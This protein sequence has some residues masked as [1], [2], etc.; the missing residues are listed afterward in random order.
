MLETLLILLLGLSALLDTSA[1]NE[2]LDPDAERCQ[3][4]ADGLLSLSSCGITD[5]DFDDI[6]SCLDAA[7]PE[8]I[9]TL[10]LSYNQ[11]STLPE[12]IFG[13]LTALETLHLAS[14]ELTTL[15]QGIFGGLPALEYLR[16][17]MP[18]ARGRCEGR[19]Q[20]TRSSPNSLVIRSHAYQPPPCSY[21][22]PRTPN[23]CFWK[24]ADPGE[25]ALGVFQGLPTLTILYLEGN[26]LECLP[27]T[28]LV[29]V[30]DDASTS[31]NG[32]HVDAYGDE[33]GCSIEGVI[34]NVCGQETCTPG[35]EGYTCADGATRSPVPGATPVPLEDGMTRSPLPG[36][37]RSPVPEA[38]LAPLGLG[39]TRSP[40]PEATLVYSYHGMTRSPAPESTP[41]PEPM[42]GTTLAPNSRG[43]LAGLVP[44]LLFSSYMPGRA[45]T[46]AP[47]IVVAPTPPLETEAPTPGTA[48]PQPAPE[49]TLAPTSSSKGSTSDSTSIVVGVLSA[50]AGAALIALAVLG[51][52]RRDARQKAA[53]PRS[54]PP[55]PGGGNLEQGLGPVPPPSFTTALALARVGDEGKSPSAKHNQASPPPYAPAEGVGGG[56]IVPRSAPTA[57]VLGAAED[58]DAAGLG[59]E[60]RAAVLPS[61]EKL[62]TDTTST[63]THSTANVS[64]HE[65]AELA[66]FQQ[67]QDVPE[68]A[69]VANG[70]RPEQA[71]GSGGGG[72]RGAS[73][74]ADHPNSSDD[75]GLG[76]AVLGAAQELARHCQVPGISEAAAVLCIM[77]N[78]FTD[79]REND[80]AS[81]SRLKQCRS[82]VMALKRA[83][84]VVGKGGDTT[85]EAARILI[86][87]VHDAIFDLVELIKTF[88][89]KNKLSKLFLSTLFKRRQDELDAVV[90]RA[91]TRL[92]LGL[93]LQI[94]HDM[95]SVK[96]SMR[97]M[98][99]DV[100]AVKH[101]V[102]AVEEG[103]NLYRQASQTISCG[104]NGESTT[105]ESV[106]EAR[107][108]RR[109]RKLDQVEIP[110]DQLFITTDLLGKGG[111][112]EVYLADYNG[113][114]AAA[115]VLY[116]AHDLGALDENQ[117]QRETRQ[118]KG[119]LREL[120]AMIRLRSPNTVN[121][122]GAVTSL[123]DRMVLVMELLPNGDLLTLLRRSTKPLHEEKSRQIIGD[124]CAGMA[125]LHGKNTVHGDLKSANVL[126]DGGGRAKIGDFGTSRWSQHTNSTGLATY[127]TKANQSTQMSLAWSAPEVLE[128]GGS[129]YKSDVYSF[130]VVVWEVL[131]RELPWANK[132]RPRDI[133]SAVLM[134]IRPSFHVDAPADIVDIAKACWGG[135]P[136]ERT[137]FSAI[138][139]GMDAKRWRE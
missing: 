93:Q 96:D 34:D 3:S 59:G 129:T 10:G 15:S 139:E 24:L 76:H 109:Q 63:A 85:G 132:T 78:L 12:G 75:L 111:F 104:S 57:V 90:D 55:A 97:S 106:A 77:A 28:T 49:P 121:V 17:D 4:D 13:G 84:K 124:I 71:F 81:D 135:E 116:I 100:S 42:P 128:S 9:T 86:E 27:S 60:G 44:L 35:D 19:A 32:I 25:H 43:R 119:F 117:E 54:D 99:D 52:C 30:D 6:A 120:E 37:T 92:Q 82:I 73:W 138:L 22:P 51:K 125:F 62:A 102:K 41:G 112:G 72:S 115:K 123:A 113:H 69:P 108:I 45:A 47:L 14:N 126:L 64:T 21:R 79:S 66:V 133:L 56:D 83:E 98:E 80:R 7:G 137:T 127:T 36:A 95:G 110:E 91:I 131:S 18:G 130:G 2:C 136:E 68:D 31:A 118:R 29:K 114:N 26:S 94:G 87:D 107:S 23:S 122:Y 33:C 46:P 134:G 53:Q 88:Q 74:V 50:V 105:S 16:V 103:M 65:R 61:A 20:G 5:A 70:P 89:S 1:V 39:A 38:T 11:L 40:V 101:G 58:R 67:R 8:T 48:T